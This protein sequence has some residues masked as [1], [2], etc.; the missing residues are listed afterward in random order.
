MKNTPAY[1][2]FSFLILGPACVGRNIYHDQP[3]VHYTRELKR[4]WTL[5]T[6]TQIDA[7]DKGYE[8]SGGVV[9]EDTLI[10]GSRVKGVTSIYPGLQKTRWVFP[11]KGGVLSELATDRKHV[12]F[13]G[14]DGFFYCLDA[15]KGRVLWK[16]EV[17]VGL[18]SKPTL[19]GGRVLVTT[20]DDTVYSFD[21]LTGKWLWSYKRRSA[22]TT[23]VSTVSAPTVDQGE[24]LVGMSDGF[25]LSLALEDGQLKW[26]R[27]LHFGSKFT[28]IDATPIVLRDRIYV[29]SFD[30][31][32]FALDRKN[33]EI[34]WKFEAGATRP[35][36]FDEQSFYLPGTDGYIY[37]ISR[38][39]GKMLWK[40]ELDRGT[41]TVILKSK[42]EKRLFFGTSYQYVYWLNSDTGQLIDRFNIGDGSGVLSN[43]FAVAD[44]SQFYLLSMGGNLY[45]FLPSKQIQR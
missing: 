18:A 21:A 26:E 27:R 36:T 22:T 33:A 5:P 31:A 12:F 8:Q 19:A 1:L 13:V 17:R 44:A 2:L 23:Q 45:Q 15:Q 40:F 6:R 24:V 10:F 7:G 39:T 29:S 14:N 38:E 30:G 41:A 9:F 4:G 35:V 20:S 28:D 16:Y 43:P 34:L 42:D 3:G 37:K 25:L 11:V 32:F